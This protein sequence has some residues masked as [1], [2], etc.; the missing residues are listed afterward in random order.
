MTRLVPLS[1]SYGHPTVRRHPRSLA[2][3]WPAEYA[4]PIELAERPAPFLAEQQRHPSPRVW[5][6][7][8]AFGAVLLVGVLVWVLLLAGCGGGDA[9][10]DERGASI[11]PVDCRAHPELCQ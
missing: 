4:D 3:A 8:D 9:T 7:S 10:D 2:E 6:L 5:R 1:Q 11:G